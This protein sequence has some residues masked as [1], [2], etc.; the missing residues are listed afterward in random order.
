MKTQ[1]V[2]IGY[3]QQASAFNTSGLY[4]ESVVN[5]QVECHAA[6]SLSDHGFR[7]AVLRALPAMPFPMDKDDEAFFY[8]EC[9]RHLHVFDRAED[10]YIS[11]FR[12]LIEVKTVD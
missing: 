10:F 1:G 11:C 2:S 8:P 9:R 4:P 7:K 12:W 5:G 6:K 3:S